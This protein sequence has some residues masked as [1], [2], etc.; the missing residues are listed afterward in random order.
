MFQCS[1][2]ASTGASTKNDGAS[3]TPSVELKDFRRLATRYDRLARNF[4]ASV[5]IVA[6]L[7]WWT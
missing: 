1:R 3:R 2:F 4:L 6:A 5:Y 7:V